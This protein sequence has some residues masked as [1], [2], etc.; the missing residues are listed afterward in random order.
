MRKQV[1]HR[2]YAEP[3]ERY[4]QDDWVPTRKV[5]AAGLGGALV[6]IAI[7]LGIDISPEL[8]AAITTVV[9]F[10]VGFFACSKKR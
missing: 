7:A 8:A 9:G 5:G 3:G 4:V 2:R 1:K 10:A 6:T